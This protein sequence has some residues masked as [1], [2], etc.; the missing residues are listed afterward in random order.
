VGL[1]AAD[2]TTETASFHLPGQRVQMRQFSVITALDLLRRHL[3][4]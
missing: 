4:S 3:R 1:A 2:D